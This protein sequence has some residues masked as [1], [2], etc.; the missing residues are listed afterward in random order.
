MKNFGRYLLVGMFLG[1]FIGCK[2]MPIQMTQVAM[3]ESYV[4]SFDFPDGNQDK[5]LDLL[6]GTDVATALIDNKTD[7]YKNLKDGKC[8]AQG[9]AA[10]LFSLLP[11]TVESEKRFKFMISGHGRYRIYLKSDNILYYSAD[12]RIKEQI[13]DSD[14]LYN[15]HLRIK[16]VQQLVNHFYLSEPD[17]RESVP[18]LQKL[19]ER[20]SGIELDLDVKINQHPK[21]KI[22]Y[23]D[24]NAKHPISVNGMKIGGLKFNMMDIYLERYKIFD[25]RGV[26]K[27]V[28]DDY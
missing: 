5:V 22:F 14:S 11:T 1:S 9:E 25:L 23:V 16:F 21:G 27:F 8:E 4:Q 3:F 26:N 24:Y 12:F 28:R 13:Y 15:G 6:L 7:Q 20:N 17:F 10:I 2:I 18:L 19:R